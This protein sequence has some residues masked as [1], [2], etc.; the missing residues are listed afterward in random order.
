MPGYSCLVYNIYSGVLFSHQKRFI[1]QHVWTLQK[2]PDTERRIVYDSTYVR[3]LGVRFTDTESRW[4]GPVV[5]EG[6]GSSVF[7]GDRVSVWEDEKVLEMD[8]GGGGDGFP[9]NMNMLNAT[10]LCTLKWLRC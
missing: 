6:L 3:S 4:W 10:E 7:Q 5:G 9:N 1:V 2:K 8:V